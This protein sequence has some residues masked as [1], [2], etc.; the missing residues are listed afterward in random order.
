MPI[1]QN[2]SPRP[3]RPKREGKYVQLTRRHQLEL[4][5]LRQACR[6]PKV[7][8]KRYTD[9]SVVGAGSCY[10]ARWIICKDCGT[11][12]IIFGR[13]K[14]EWKKKVELTMSRQGGF[15]DERLGC[16]VHYGWEVE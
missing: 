13:S 6:H 16:W 11:K 12:K 3:P 8:L 4:D 1:Q 14:A 10:P 9:T 2:L 7:A 5:Q 15:E